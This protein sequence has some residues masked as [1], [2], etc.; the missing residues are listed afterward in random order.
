MKRWP[1]FLALALVCG[2]P[3][4]RAEAETIIGLTTANQLF[5]FDSTT[6]G[7]T[8]APTAVTGLAAG[9]TLVGIDIRPVD[10]QLIGLGIVGG[11]GTVYSINPAT[12]A[13]TAINTGIALTGV[14][15]EIDFNPAVNALRIVSG[16][17]QNLRIVN[18]GAGT[19]NV[20]TPLN[21][22]TPS[23]VGAAYSNNFVGALSTTLY[24][25]AI[26]DQTNL[27]LE[28]QGSPG[29]SPVSP[30]SGTLFLV[31]PLGFNT[32]DPSSNPI[33][34]DISGSTGTAFASRASSGLYTINLTTGAGT[35]VGQIGPGS[36]SV[37]DI[38]AQGGP[39]QI[40]PEPG[41]I[42][43]LGLGIAGLLG[44]QWRRRKLARR[45]E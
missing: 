25:I 21:P 37:S 22:G 32:G 9:S 2:A 29:G 11:V 15:F 44:S 41:S 7:T 8:T 33:G 43:L 35:L 20:D 4:T 17:G 14:V 30:N 1:V 38:T 13:A 5:T 23:V 10:G 3:V 18:G 28:T 42:T 12:G 40:V 6:P 16:T 24:D 19:V 27:I 34:F 36:F 39:T 26:D 45:A 31:G